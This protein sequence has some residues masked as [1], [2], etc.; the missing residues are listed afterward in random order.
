MQPFLA[1]I[2]IALVLAFG[3]AAVLD[4]YQQPVDSAYAT[5]GTRL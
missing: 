1:A 5:Q 3:A 4:G 2:A